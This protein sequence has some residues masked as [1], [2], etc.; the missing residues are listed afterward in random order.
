MGSKSAKTGSAARV[1]I[2]AVG[3]DRRRVRDLLALVE[4]A[5][6]V[7]KEKKAEGNDLVAMSMA[8]YQALL[9]SAMP[10]VDQSA[11]GSPAGTKARGRRVAAAEGATEKG[12]RPSRRDTPAAEQA[13]VRI[14]R[15]RK[16]MTQEQLAQ[17]VGLSKSFLS[18]I[19]NGKKTG[20]IKTLRAI[21][22]ALE[23]ELSSLAI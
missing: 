4:P 6:K 11:E 13:S 21:A 17:K 14:W 2:A 18:E 19:E 5:A 12:S 16:G 9:R 22:A 23:I 7:I 1:R 8:T 10:A 15:E 20:S 3:E